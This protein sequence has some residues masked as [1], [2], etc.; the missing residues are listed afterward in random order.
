MSI[1]TLTQEKLTWINI[2]KIDAEALKYLKDNYSFH[3]LDFEDLQSEQQTPKLD[4][5]KNY[6]FLVLQFPH[7]R[8][9]DQTVVAHE[10]DVFVGEG[11][12]I[13]IQH[14]KSK[15]MK[16]F[17]YRCMNNRKVKADWMSDSSGYL[18]FRLIEAL[19][20]NSRPILSN[21]GKQIYKL[22]EVIF[23]GELD[24][25]MVRKLAVHRRS[26]LNFRRIVDPNRYLVSTLSHT[27][28]PFLDEKL[29]IYFDDV[30]DFV[31]KIWS[32][33]DSYKDTIN[34][35]HVTVESLINQRTNK[36][37]GTLTVISVALLPL[38]LLSGIYGMN[39]T[40]LPFS[41]NPTWVWGM[42]AS[43]IL[44]ILIVIGVLKKKRWL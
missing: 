36:V 4:S 6:L 37:I 13:T 3:H 5:Y 26:V 41:K 11:Y 27:R 22:E 23:D 35:L 18:L 32:I 21:I 31:N 9:S 29:S 8:A 17:F 30:S 38:T 1:K 43:L 12:L 28:K 2:D 19:F 33:T 20:Q 24:T 14:T 16:N 42:F 25:E 15:E 44:V 34:G 7:W 10:I 39:V 40:G